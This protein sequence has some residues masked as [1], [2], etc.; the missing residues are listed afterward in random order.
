MLSLTDTPFHRTGRD[1]YAKSG[2]NAFLCRVF[3]QWELSCSNYLY[4]F[5]KLIR[6]TI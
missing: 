4:A 5:L 3:D 6:Y 1:K 2:D